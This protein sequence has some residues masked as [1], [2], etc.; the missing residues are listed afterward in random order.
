MTNLSRR[1]TGM[2]WGDNM[3]VPR[4]CSNIWAT[5]KCEIQV[6]QSNTRCDA[7]SS[8][9]DTMRDS[10][11]AWL[12]VLIP[13]LGPKPSI[14]VFGGR[15]T[16][17][18]KTRRSTM[19]SK[20]ASRTVTPITCSRGSSSATVRLNINA[21]V[22]T[23]HRCCQEQSHRQEK[24][25]TAEPTSTYATTSHGSDL[26]A[27]RECSSA[28]KESIDACIV[29]GKLPM[30]FA[31]Y[32]FQQY[33]LTHVTAHLADALLVAKVNMVSGCFTAHHSTRK[34]VSNG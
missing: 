6:K 13:A 30:C 19:W 2:P 22:Y 3:S 32:G 24:K 7:I 34:A 4:I 5:S 12:C 29:S 1:S 27:Q 16:N 9:Q 14:R 11:C 23:N 33:G 10:C 8:Y 20:A 25:H 28:R 15:C 18:E 31:W 21:P 17:S 26:P